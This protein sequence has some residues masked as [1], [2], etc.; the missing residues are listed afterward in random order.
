[1]GFTSPTTFLHPAPAAQQHSAFES[2][3]IRNMHKATHTAEIQMKCWNRRNMSKHFCTN[4]TGKPKTEAEDSIFV[5]WL[6]IT[7]AIKRCRGPEEMAVMTDKAP[8][9]SRLQKVWANS[10][11]YGLRCSVSMGTFCQRTHSSQQHL[12]T[13]WLVAC[14]PPITRCSVCLISIMVQAK[15]IYP[16]CGSFTKSQW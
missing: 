16:T 1:M 6:T 9:W 8:S 12:C 11:F 10:L 4:S 2:S 5:V 7:V 13:I 14:Y 15:I 3:P